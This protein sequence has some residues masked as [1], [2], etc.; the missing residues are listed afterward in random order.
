LRPFL[1][2][3][4]KYCF[5]A[6]RVNTIRFDKA[7][8]LEGNL[9]LKI[10]YLN[11]PAGGGKHSL[12]KKAAEFARP[13]EPVLFCQPTVDLINQ[14]VADMERDY[15]Q[16]IVRAIHKDNSQ[17]PVKDIINSFFDE[18]P[19]A[20]ILVITQS[21]FERIDADFDRYQWHLIIDEI[22]NVT[23][24]FD[25]NLPET[26]GLITSLISASPVPDTQYDLITIDDDEQLEMIAK[27]KHKDEVWN[28]FKELAYTLLS[29]R[30][31][32]YVDRDAYENLINGTGSRLNIFSRLSG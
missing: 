2:T 5:S 32:N 6:F 13:G 26:H 1:T 17:K 19:D 16:L 3:I 25:A 20:Y 28:E 15:P 9:F 4:L 29:P 12:I 23:R 7:F 14:T 21:A 24:C 31:D 30:W 27:N 22:P 10:E 18:I 8:N 11:S